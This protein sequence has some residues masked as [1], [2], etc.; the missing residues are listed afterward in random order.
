M[1]LVSTIAVAA[2]AAFIGTAAIGQTKPVVPV[3]PKITAPAV[4]A[5]AVTA[6]AIVAPAVVAPAKTMT[7]DEKAMKSKECSKEADTKKLHGKERK[8]FR[9]DC[10]KKAA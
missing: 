5:P 3:V 6:P 7:P 1:K 8:K 10:K 4:T 2:F 9:E